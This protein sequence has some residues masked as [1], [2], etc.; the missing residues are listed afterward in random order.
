MARSKTQVIGAAL[1]VALFCTAPL[2]ANDLGDRRPSDDALEPG[3]WHLLNND[4][5]PAQLDQEVWDN[6]WRVWEPKLKKE[7]EK[8]SDAER[9]AMTLSRYGLTEAPGREG[10]IPLQYA[11]DGRGGWVLN[12]FS[13][14][15]GKVNGQVIPGLPNTH[16]ALETL[17]QEIVETKRLLGREV[18]AGE[19][20]GSL[21][22]PLGKSNGTTNAIIFGVVLANYRDADLNLHMDRPMPKLV[23]ND[24]DAPPWWNMKYKTHLYADGFAGTGH[25]ALMQFMLTPENGPEKFHESE[26]DFRK[27]YDWILHLEPPKYP[28]P[29]DES[30]ARQ[31]EAIFNQTCAGCHGTY[32]ENPQFPNEIVP[33]E[34]V[35]TDRARLD[36]LTPEMRAGYEVSWFSNYGEKKAI[37]DPGGYLAQPLHGIWAS[38]PYLHNGSVPTLYHL[39]YPEERPLIWRRTEDGYDTEKIGLA[40]TVYDELPADAKRNAKERRKYFDTRLF[41]KSAEGHLFP[42]ELND[43]EKRAVLEYLKTL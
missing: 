41:A 21:L 9:R 35:G 16:I 42:D 34:V 2:L 31:G 3:Y 38:A 22:V 23:H 15:G 8:A 25:R 5:V 30:L 24:H 7:A 17:F 36:S 32:G 14:H 26:D 33:I 20:A 19:A 12:C 37:H 6:L 29:I 27:I 10:G 39:F 1:A 11:D 40:V 43:E 4:Y 13:C 18:S 28:W